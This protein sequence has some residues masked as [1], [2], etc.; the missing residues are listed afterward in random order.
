MDQLFFYNFSGRNL[1]DYS[2]TDFDS[3]LVL[4]GAIVKTG[5]QLTFPSGARVKAI[6]LKGATVFPGFSDAHVHLSQTGIS[7]LG[8][9]LGQARNL[10]DIF[11]LIAEESARVSPIM[12]FNLQEQMLKENRLP[13]CEEL[14]KISREKIIW[15][16]RKDLHSAVLNSA[17]LKWAVRT[18]PDMAHE[19]GF[20]CGES[21]NRLAYLLIDEVPDTMLR[22]GYQLT[23][24]QCYAK[25]VVFI[26]ALEGSSRSKREAELAADFFKQGGLEGVVYHQSEN[27]DYAVKN[28]WPGFGGCLLVDGSFG[29]RT[30]ALNDPYDDAA[31]SCGN[32]YLHGDEIEAL[33]K[34]ARENRLQLALHAIGDRA[35]DVVTSCYLWAHEKFKIKVLPDRIE[36]FILPTAK[37]LRAARASETMICVQPVFDYL[38]GGSNGLYRQR[39]GPERAARCNPFKTMLDLGIP[40]AA[41]SDSPVTPIDPLLGIHSLVNHQNPDERIDLNSAL[42]LYTIEP[43][44]FC[45][46]DKARGQLKP[47]FKADFVCLEQD[48]FMVSPGRLK[49]VKVSQTFINGLSQA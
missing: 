31:D 41:G 22:R 24:Q 45:G 8:C 14:D 1:P 2:R 47:G 19:Q 7:L 27:P 3:M 23:A 43:Y 11:S 18:I 21:Y 30:A 40:L 29:T 20:V 33:L 34:R 36:H 46:K 17:G 39:L 37:A 26:H 13:T 15:L 6:D 28:G 12:G 49:D 42:S 5:F 48:P 44:R 4:N 9:D 35:L 25:G 32:L 16:A 10:A 38:W